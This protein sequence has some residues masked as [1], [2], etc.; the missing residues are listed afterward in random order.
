VNKESAGVTKLTKET[1]RIKE[2]AIF[3]SH[4]SRWASPEIKIHAYPGRTRSRSARI[5]PVTVIVVTH[6]PTNCFRWSSFKLSAAQLNFTPGV[7]RQMRILSFAV[8]KGHPLLPVLRSVQWAG[9]SSPSLLRRAV[10][11]PF[12]IPTKVTATKTK[13]PM[14]LPS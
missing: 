9:A 14:I 7:G 12:F 13:S 11:S 3:S 6:C 8:Q 2:S 10:K 5:R 4:P 1:L